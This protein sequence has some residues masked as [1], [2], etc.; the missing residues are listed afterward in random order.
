[1]YILARKTK[2]NEMLYLCL[3]ICIHGLLKCFLKGI[4]ELIKQA[5]LL[6]ILKKFGGCGSLV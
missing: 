6:T 5:Y 2:D 1:M 3:R 4:F